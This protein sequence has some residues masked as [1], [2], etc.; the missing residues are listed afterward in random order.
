MQYFELLSFLIYWNV[1]QA[2]V[3][4][5]KLLI[6]FLVENFHQNCF[7]RL[8]NFDL[9]AQVTFPKV[10]FNVFFHTVSFSECSFFSV[11]ECVKLSIFIDII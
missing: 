8:S 2:T 1:F 11:F 7:F 6:K 3:H 4:S 5:L 9:F 10:I